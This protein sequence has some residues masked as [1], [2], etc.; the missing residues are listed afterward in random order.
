MKTRTFLVLVM[1]LLAI[2]A[3]FF[4]QGCSTTEQPVQPVPAP[5]LDERSGAED[6]SAVELPYPYAQISADSV[7][8]L[9][10]IAYAEAL[11]FKGLQVG[12]A[13]GA[14][15]ACISLNVPYY[16]QRDANWRW[17]KL[18]N[19]TTSTIDR[20]GCH[21]TC[22]SMLYAYWGVWNMNP[23]QLNNWAKSQGAFSGDLIIASKA[24]QYN[25]CRTVK[26]IGS[27][28]VYTY[29]ANR[30]PVVAQ[31]SQYGGH[32]VLITGFDGY[33]F[34]VKDPYQTDWTTQNQPLSG[35]VYSFR[36]YGA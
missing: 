3:A 1:A 34:W 31:T 6:A 10:R 23:R 26:Y 2:A 35:T 15:N 27:G 20:Y 7:N 21:L 22:I 32:F 28:E 33:R 29:L 8:S 16:S 19:S 25:A 36:V 24:I 17:D 30:K 5:S 13:L 11:S 14:P 18:G 4:A 9:G 12:Q